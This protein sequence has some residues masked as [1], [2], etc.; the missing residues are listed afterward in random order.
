VKAGAPK[1]DYELEVAVCSGDPTLSGCSASS[2][3]IYGDPITVYVA[4]P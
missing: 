3:F 4:V 2:A 1:G